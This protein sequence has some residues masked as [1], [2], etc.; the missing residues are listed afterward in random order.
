[1][2][3]GRRYTVLAIDDDQAVL[4]SIKVLL[5]DGYEVLTATGGPQGLDLFFRRR[6]DVVLLDLRLDGLSGFEVLSRVRA[7]DPRALIIVVTA[8]SDVRE[9]VTS[10]K[11]GAWDY[12][13]KPWDGSHLLSSVASACREVE[14]DE[15]V[16]IVCD[17]WAMMAP[18]HIALERRVR[19]ATA[20]SARA[21]ELPFPARV[22]VADAHAPSPAWSAMLAL[23]LDRFPLADWV[24]IADDAEALAGSGLVPRVAAAVAVRSYRIDHLVRRIER[25]LRAHADGDPGPRP[26]PPQVA[27]AIQRMTR[28]YGERRTVEDYARDVGLSCDRFAHIFSDAVGVPVKEYLIR[29]RIAVARRILE[30]TDHKLDEVARLAGFGDTS[31]FSRAF[32]SAAGV[33]PG[34]FRARFRARVESGP[35]GQPRPWRGPGDLGARS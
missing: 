16:L 5:G 26:F 29:L 6:V 7:I 10:I 9:A 12:I 25:L 15:G 32:T 21:I 11:L 3:N 19:V 27:A 33:R 17:D 8:A 30:E 24:L 23:L 20:S 34:E 18:L 1:M 31:N 2:R 28:E 13:T 4:D 35:D 22:V 14:A